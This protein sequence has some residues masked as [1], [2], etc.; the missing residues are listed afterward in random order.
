M[1]GVNGCHVRVQIKSEMKLAESGTNQK[2]IRLPQGANSAGSNGFRIFYGRGNC[3][4]PAFATAP[5]FAAVFLEKS[6]ERPNHG[7]RTILAESAADINYSSVSFPFM[8]SLFENVGNA[9]HV[10]RQQRPLLQ[11]QQLQQGTVE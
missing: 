10:A 6:Y 4:K 2:R 7:S 9:V 11:I 3:L 8:Q 5:I 1:S